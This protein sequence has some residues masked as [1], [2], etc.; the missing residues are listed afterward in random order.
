MSTT[1]ISLRDLPGQ[2][3]PR[4]VALVARPIYALL[5]A[6]ELVYLAVLAVMLFRPPDIPFYGLDRVALALLVAVCGLRALCWREKLWQPDPVTWPLL[7]LTG[8]GFIYAVSQRYQAE[9]WSVFAAKWC[10]PLIFYHLAGRVFT[11]LPARRKLETFLLLVLAYLI[12]IAV[13]F[14]LDAKALIYPRFIVEEGIGIHVE[15]ARGPFLQ[16]VANGVTLNLL[17]LVALDS[18]RRGRLRGTWAA[19]LL[20]TLPFAI[21]ATLTRAVWL[22]FALSIVLTG[23]LT[24]SPRL[25]RASLAMITA[26]ALGISALLSM[27]TLGGSFSQ[28]AEESG[29]V[30]FR[31]AM[32]EAGWQMFSEKPLFGWGEDMQAEL[33]RRISD[34]HQ[35]A[36]YFHN[37]FLEIAVQHG[38]LGLSLFAWMV[39][40]LLREGR[41]HATPVR[42]DGEFLDRGWRELWPVL[43]FVF[44]LNACFVGMNYQFVNGLLFTLAGILSAQN[45]RP[46]EAA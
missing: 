3:G 28:R 27:E 29:P 10:V 30:L 7:A 45:R 13:F 39:V 11:T 17:G 35:E 33:G 34:F 1:E 2:I 37:T 24:T 16:A 42:R 46:V 31:A 4:A 32:Y 40:G 5:R 41:K 9:I 36:Y 15:R 6:P 23:L 43:I 44:L 25:R 18:F 22:G 20:G 12:A 19:L 26:G 38:M 8:L 21:L 14:L